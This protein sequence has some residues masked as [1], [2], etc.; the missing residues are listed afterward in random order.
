MAEWSSS[1]NLFQDLKRFKLRAD[2]IGPEMSMRGF[3]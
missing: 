1:E 2:L 3:G